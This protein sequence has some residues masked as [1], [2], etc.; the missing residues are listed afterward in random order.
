MSRI[1]SA[2]ASLEAIGTAVSAS[3]SIRVTALSLALEADRRVGDVVEDDQVGALAAEL[4]AGALEPPPPVLGGEAD[5][6]LLRP[7][8]RR[9]APARMSSVGS[10][11]SSSPSWR[12]S[13]P[14]ATSRRAEV[15]RGGGHQQDVG[16]GELGRGGRGQLLGGLDVDAAHAGGLRQ[17]DVGGDQ[18]HLGAA[19]GGGGGE[20]DAHAAAGAVADEAD[21]VDRLAGAAGGDQHPQAVPGPLAARQRRLDPGQQAL[22]VGQAAAAV[23][24]ARGELALVGLDHLDPALAQGRQ[25]RLGRR[26][27]VHAVVHRRRHQ[28]RRRAGEEGGGQHRVGD[29][30][31]QLGDRVGRGRARPGRRR[32]WRPARGGRS[33]RDRARPSPGKAPRI[34]SRSNSEISTG[35]PTIPSK[36]AAPTKRVAVSVISTRTPC[37][38][39]VARRASS[40]AL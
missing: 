21:R 20:G 19:A 13:L 29:A 10:S 17:G 11:W 2:I 12:L 4:G 5:D 15:G 32:S 40:S 25:V 16:G 24:A 34:G 38:A 28:A 7:A 1:A 30:G 27:G 9:R 22:G 39:S 8:G 36:E 23:L 3:A 6:G 35:A 26:V 31:G 33:G 37:P 14:A 18:G